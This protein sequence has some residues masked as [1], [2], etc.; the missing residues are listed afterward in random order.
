MLYERGFTAADVW[1]QG[2]FHSSS[3]GEKLEN[4]AEHYDHRC[5]IQAREPRFFCALLNVLDKIMEGYG[6]LRSCTWTELSVHIFTNST[7]PQSSACAP[8]D[9]TLLTCILIGSYRFCIIPL[10]AVCN[11]KSKAQLWRSKSFVYFKLLEIVVSCYLYILCI[12]WCDG[13]WLRSFC[14]EMS[15]YTPG[16]NSEAMG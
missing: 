9:L 10:L 7:M 5:S 4:S 2:L 15:K 1:R 14:Y 12:Y 6:S 16:N 8:C 11:G 13:R 3:L